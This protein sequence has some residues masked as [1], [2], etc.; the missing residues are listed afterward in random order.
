MGNGSKR[1]GRYRLIAEIGHGGMAEV[2]LALLEGDRRLQQA[3]RAQ[4]DPSGA[5]RGPGDPGHVPRRGAARRAAQ[6]PQRGAD[7]RGG[8]GGR[9]LLHRH[10]VPRGAAAQPHP[11]S[12]RARGRLALAMQLR[13]LADVLAGLHHAHEL[14]DFDGTPA[15]RRAP[16][17]HAA[18]RVRHLRRAVKVVDFGIAKV[19]GSSSETRAGVVKGKVAYMAPE[20]AR[21]EAVD[22]RDRR[23]RRGRDALGGGDGDAAL[24][25]AVRRRDPPSPHSRRDPLGEGG[26]PEIPEALEEIREQG[27]RAEPRRAVRDGRRAAHRD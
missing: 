20:Q 18:E 21:G 19:N 24:P 14:C 2:Y 17:R 7:P 1:L 26:E 16:R 4:E 10:G 22:R 15:R 5:R 27:C 13:V 9:A 23:L 3:G 25:W 11:A 12:L 8:A 6:P